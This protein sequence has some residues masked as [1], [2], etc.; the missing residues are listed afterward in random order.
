MI[1]ELTSDRVE[2]LVVVQ[3]IVVSTRRAQH[4]ARKVFL[5]CS[6][7]ENVR[8]VT[9]NSGFNSAHVPPSCEGSKTAAAI[10]RCPP[11]PFQIISE[12]CEFI[13][14]QTLKLQEL[15]EHVPIGEMPRSIDLCVDQGANCVYVVSIVRLCA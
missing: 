7:C 13:D 11:G 3:G 9:I 15:P 14:Q 1:R 5:K 2:E 10:E 4:K 6:N 12:R 8:E